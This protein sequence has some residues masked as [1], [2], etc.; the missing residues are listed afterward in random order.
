MKYILIL[1]NILQSLSRIRNSLILCLGNFN[2]IGVEIYLDKNVNLISK[3]I[4]L[5]VWYCLR[6]FYVPVMHTL[7]IWR[8]LDLL[9]T[10]FDHVTHILTKY[11]SYARSASGINV[12]SLNISLITFLE[13]GF[14]LVFSSGTMMKIDLKQLYS[15]KWEATSS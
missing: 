3:S 4:N 12:V 15:T 6:E 10:L 5:T 1:I 14:W 11:T 13:T 9:T 7:H 2:Y 8:L